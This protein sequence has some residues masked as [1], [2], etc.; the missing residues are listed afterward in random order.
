MQPIKEKKGVA[1][2]KASVCD[3]PCLRLSPR[4]HI[5]KIMHRFLRYVSAAFVPE[6][7]RPAKDSSNILDNDSVSPSSRDLQTAC[8]REGLTLHTPVSINKLG[9]LKA[10]KG[11]RGGVTRRKSGEEET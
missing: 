8:A 5:Y 7:K 2:E 4:T 10:A 9:G 6:I 3:T 1:V 11:S